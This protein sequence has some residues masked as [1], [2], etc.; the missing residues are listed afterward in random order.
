VLSAFRLLLNRRDCKG[1]KILLS[2]D[3]DSLKGEMQVHAGTN[4]ASKQENKPVQCSAE[5]LEWLG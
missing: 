2:Q 3:L 4:Q 5:L 1:F